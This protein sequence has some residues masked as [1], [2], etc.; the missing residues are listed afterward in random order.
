MIAQGSTAQGRHRTTTPFLLQ[1]SK[2][3]GK[4]CDNDCSWWS[5]WG[6][7][8]CFSS[9]LLPG[10]KTPV[11]FWHLMPLRWE[12]SFSD[13]KNTCSSFVYNVYI[14]LNP[15]SCF[16]TERFAL[17]SLLS[18]ALSQS[19]SS[20]WWQSHVS[21]NFRNGLQQKQSSFLLYQLFNLP[22]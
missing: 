18:M 2:R 17:C 16:L 8:C 6:V 7:S 9:D 5:W 4:I 12:L 11:W 1:Q 3:E 20:G 19:P 22:L 21:V 14:C 10:K 15:D 13:N